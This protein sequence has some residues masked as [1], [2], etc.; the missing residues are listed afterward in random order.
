MMRNESWLASSN[1]SLL[2]MRIHCFTHIRYEHTCSPR[3]EVVKWSCRIAHCSHM[4]V[5]GFCLTYNYLH[6]FRAKTMM[7]YIVYCCVLRM[8]AHVHAGFVM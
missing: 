1:F 4:P 6:S 3:A 8:Y 2:Y 5:F 7:V